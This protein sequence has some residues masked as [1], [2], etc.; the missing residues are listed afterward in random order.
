MDGIRWTNGSNLIDEWMDGI[1]LL[2]GI[3][4]LDGRI[5]ECISSNSFLVV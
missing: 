3:G 4:L 1:R 2:D 5:D